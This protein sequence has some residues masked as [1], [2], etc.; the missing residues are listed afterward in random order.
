[1]A[2]PTSRSKTSQSNPTSL[3]YLFQIDVGTLGIATVSHRFAK[4]LD[5]HR[6]FFLFTFYK[7]EKS[8]NKLQYNK[9]K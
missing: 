1:M 5:V 2:W 4:I 6:H 3:I 7:E 9:K 8:E